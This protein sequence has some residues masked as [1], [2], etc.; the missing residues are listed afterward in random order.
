MKVF[1]SKLLVKAHIQKLLD[2]LPLSL[3]EGLDKAAIAVTAK[4]A[5]RLMIVVQK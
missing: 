4:K 5:Y 3:W 1:N 2:F